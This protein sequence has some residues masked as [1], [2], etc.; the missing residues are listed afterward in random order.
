MRTL[1]DFLVKHVAWIVFI[2][3][4]TLSCILLFTFNPYQRSTFFGTS[5]TA[6]ARV[7]KWSDQVT[8]YFG[9]RSVN[10]DLLQHNGELEQ[11]V[12]ALRNELLQYTDSTT[13]TSLTDENLHSKYDF[14]MARAINNSVSHTDNYIT[15]DKGTRHGVTPDMAVV[16]QQGVVGVVTVV[17]EHNAVALSLLNTKWHLS[18]KVKNTDCFGSMTWDARSAQYAT[19]EE[20]PRHVNFNVGDT[21]VTSGYSTVFPEGIMVGVIDGYAEQKNDNFYSVRVKL[22]CDFTQLGAVRIMYNKLQDEQRQLEK[23]ARR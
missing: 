18:C 11:E 22:S 23:E 6:V 19:L 3:Y 9:L 17:N 1:I 14:I 13:I 12:L 20:L 7:Y 21:I 15:L 10:K 16:N 2:I 4:V 8:G 5:N